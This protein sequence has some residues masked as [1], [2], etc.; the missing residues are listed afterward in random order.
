MWAAAGTSYGSL[1]HPF[2][3]TEPIRTDLVGH[4]HMPTPEESED[5]RRRVR[6]QRN[7]GAFRRRR[8]CRVSRAK[9]RAT[10]LRPKKFGV[11]PHSDWVDDYT[12]TCAESYLVPSA[13]ARGG[14]LV[15][16][17]LCD[18]TT[19]PCQFPAYP[20]TVR[21]KFGLQAFRDAPVGDD[22]EQ[23][24]SQPTLLPGLM[25]RPVVCGSTL[26][27]VACSITC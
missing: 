13:F 10:R 6:S 16:E 15:K 7:Y 25:G 20:G 12:S 3:P 5:D 19:L 8:S 17:T 9:C 21:W 4:N 1:Q 23:L 14:E 2:S 11:V 24:E 18:P 26:R 22:G 27:V